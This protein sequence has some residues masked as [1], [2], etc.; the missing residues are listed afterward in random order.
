MFVDH[1]NNSLTVTSMY[2]Y[3]SSSCMLYLNSSYQTEVVWG[4]PYFYTICF[5][6]NN[7]DFK[8]AKL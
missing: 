2:I 3:Q 4:K 5:S 7:L 1:I 8:F 6:D